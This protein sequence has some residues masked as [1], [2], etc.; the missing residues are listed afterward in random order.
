M[1]ASAFR[2]VILSQIYYYNYYCDICTK[3]HNFFSHFDDS[4][5]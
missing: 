3:R 5:C 2:N 4:F 1:E